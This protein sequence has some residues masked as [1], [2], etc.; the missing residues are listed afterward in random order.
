ME[1]LQINTIYSKEI[2]KNINNTAL[3]KILLMDEESSK[4]FM[5]IINYKKLNEFVNSDIKKKDYLIENNHE[6][7]NKIYNI[8]SGKI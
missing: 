3:R 5:A 8:L 2:I 4:K 6:E 7:F 1:D